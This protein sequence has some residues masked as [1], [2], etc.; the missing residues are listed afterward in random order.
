VSAAVSMNFRRFLEMFLVHVTFPLSLPWVYYRCARAAQRARGRT[1]S[2]LAQI[3]KSRRPAVDVY[4]LS[5]RLRL[6][7]FIF[8]STL[9]VRARVC[10]RAR[11]ALFA[12]VCLSVSVCVIVCVCVSVCVLSCV[13]V[14][15][16]VFI[17]VCV[18][19][20]VRACV[21]VCVRDPATAC[22][23]HARDRWTINILHFLLRYNT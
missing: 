7:Q 4:P 20:C 17:C 13:F 15:V 19:A 8:Y 23:R 12:R 2:W 18:R 1:R 21:R 11:Y 5:K 6:L 9:I 22:C 3:R 14:C 16:C 10:A